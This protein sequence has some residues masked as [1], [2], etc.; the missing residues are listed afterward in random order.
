MESNAL[1]HMSLS[2]ATPMSPSTITPSIRLLFSFISRRHLLVLLLPATFASIIAGGVAPFMT[3]VVGQAFDAFAHFP[4]TPDPPQ[5]AR[6]ALLRD[7]GIAALQLIGLAVGALALSSLTSCLW[8][9]IGETNAMALRKA[10]YVAVSQKD[11]TW[12]DM[13]TTTDRLSTESSIGAGGLMAKFSRYPSLFPISRKSTHFYRRETDEVRMASSLASGM[14]I[15]YLTTCVTCL[16]LAFLRSWTLTLVILSAVPLLMIVQSLSQG[17]AS[18]LLAHEREQTGKAATIIDRAVTAISTVKAFNATG[19]E[20][21]RASSVFGRLR[22]A[23]K[24]LNALW[25]TTSAISQ[26]V[27]MAMFVQG[28][29]F[30]SKLV[31]EGRNSPGDVMAVF[32]ACLTASSNLQMCIPQ[33]IILAK[34]KFAMAALL[35]LV[36]PTPGI[37]L[38]PAVPITP[39][40]V[41]P[42]KYSGGLAMEGVTFAYPSRPTLPALF[43]V[44]LFLPASET[45]FIVGSSGSGKST[46]AHLLQKMYEPQKGN[47]HFDEW[48]MRTLG[49]NWLR[50]RVACVGQQGAGGVVIFDEKSVFENISA[51]VHG[52]SSRPPSLKEVEEACRAALMHEFVRDLPQGY[53][54]LIGG[55]AGVGLSGGQLQRLSIARARL[56]NPTVLILGK[57]PY[58]IFLSLN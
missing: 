48:D 46:I 12:F 1:K 6:D 17:F 47:I 23:A 29:W 4:I 19:L 41:K 30:G 9:W 10:I 37:G 27:M 20:Y 42:S 25:A 43:D 57:F 2:K 28:F 33:F 45:T 53:D 24:K 5:V 49:E 36:A 54:T 58:L 16:I 11:L 56:R 26:F 3:F 21:S 50:S 32:W 55:G 14:L 31:R 7:V 34:G 52:H 40:M 39:R 35:E 8:I 44:S 22:I 15:Q 18:P 51:A 38:L 13:R